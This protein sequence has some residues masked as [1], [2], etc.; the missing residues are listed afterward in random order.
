MTLLDLEA[1]FCVIE[2]PLSFRLTDNLSEAHGVMF[3]CPV[4]FQKNGG[5]VGTHS[6]L[7]WFNGRGVPVDRTPLPGRWNPAGTGLDDLTFVGPGAMSVQLN[8]GC[9][10]HFMVEQGRVRN[11]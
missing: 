10:A 4:C 1:E 9:G 8:G 2:S 5:N 6:V 3:L 7:C 11:C